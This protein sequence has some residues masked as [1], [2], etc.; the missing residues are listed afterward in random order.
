MPARTFTKDNKVKITVESDVGDIIFESDIA[1]ATKKY[2]EQAKY[3]KL[4]DDIFT[5]KIK[6]IT[7]NIRID[8]ETTQLELYK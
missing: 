2:F 1:I 3:K 7:I 4:R 6:P 8:L 5:R